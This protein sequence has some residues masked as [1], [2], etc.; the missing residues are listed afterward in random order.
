M[1]SY[2][3]PPFPPQLGVL[4]A[5][6][7]LFGNELLLTSVLTC[8][9]VSVLIV[10][11]ALEPALPHFNCLPRG[12]VLVCLT[13]LGTVTLKTQLSHALG[14]KDDVSTDFNIVTLL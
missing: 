10:M 8:L 5:V 4:Q 11:L 7:S 6:M 13:L 3:V 2:C 12:L 14:N 1:F 9:I